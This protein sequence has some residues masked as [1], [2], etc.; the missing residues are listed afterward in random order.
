MYFGATDSPFRDDRVR[1]AISMEID[2]AAWLMRLAT[3]TSSAPP[4]CR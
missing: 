1:R 3:A 4:A 2:R